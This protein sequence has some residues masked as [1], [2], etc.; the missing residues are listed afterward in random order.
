MKHSCDCRVTLPT[1]SMVSHVFCVK[2]N[3]CY[4]S[5]LAVD[6]VGIE[7]PNH[8]SIT[9]THV[10]PNHS[11]LPVVEHGFCCIKV[12]DVSV[13]R[14]EAEGKDFLV[15]FDERTAGPQIVFLHGQGEGQRPLAILDS[16]NLAIMPQKSDARVDDGKHGASSVW[17]EAWA[18]DMQ[19]QNGTSD[20][21]HGSLRRERQDRM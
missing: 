12:L 10:C 16:L 18:H 5:H 13:S 2:T 9:S 15:G 14:L 1:V 7:Q 19:G 21:Q 6:T 4:P 8:S 17:R 11:Y 20:F 3:R